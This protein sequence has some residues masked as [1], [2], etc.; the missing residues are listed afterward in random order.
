MSGLFGTLNIGKSSIFANQTAIDVTGHNIANTK[1]PGY[2]R[3]R[4]EMQTRRPFCTPSMNN[5]AEPGQLGT[6][7]EISQIARIRDTFLDYQIRVEMGTQGCY[8]GRDKFLRE[9]E[10]VFNEPTDTGISTLLGKFFDSWQQ[11]AKQPETSNTRT[12]VAEQSQSLANE[13][14]HTYSQLM[15]VK[16][17][18][19]SIIKQTVFDVNNMINQVNQLNQEIIQISV[20]G[21]NANDLMDRRDLLIDQLSTRFGVTIDKKGFD[22]IELN[23]SEDKAS[24]APKGVNLVQVLDPDEVGRFSYIQDIQPSKD[25]EGKPT[26]KYDIV[27]YKNG[28]TTT[29]KN[30]VVIKDVELTSEQKRNM[31]ECRVIWTDKEGNLLKKDGKAVTAK[32]GEISGVR[33][34]DIALFTPSSGE[35]QGYMSVQKD[36]DNY[37][38]QVNNL[39]KAIAYSVNAV[40]GQTEDGSKDSLL[41]FVNKDGAENEINASNIA[42]NQKIMDNKML[43][44]GSTLDVP[45]AGESDGKRALAIAGL[46]DVLMG[47]QNITGDMKREDFINKLCGGLKENEY[48]N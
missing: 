20:A 28:D 36:V 43:I 5:A 38:D 37:I 19:Q 15:K 10:S 4:A 46:R 41:F 14:N 33:L 22:A 25:A 18:A 17:N 3:Q 39:A 12:M 31:D 1:T 16:D 47:I 42:V 27:Y 29:E 26:G 9:I 24:G 13:L 11:F 48:G 45:P 44:K 7:V 8:S 23:T 2:S 6:G 35:F 34:E 30:R 32:D 21:N 40:H